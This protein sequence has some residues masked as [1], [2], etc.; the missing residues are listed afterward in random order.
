M[1]VRRSTVTITL[2]AALLVPAG[3]GLAEHATAQAAPSGPSITLDAAP[4]ADGRRALT[5]PIHVG[6]VGGTIESVTGTATPVGVTDPKRASA[7]TGFFNAGHSTWNSNALMP[8]R[9]YRVTVVA[10]APDGVKATQSATVTTANPAARL[11]A[12][13]TPAT[14]RLVGVGMPVIVNL[15]R[16]VTT[17]SG[18]AAVQKALTVTTSK[19][20][21]RASW[22]WVSSTQVQYRPLTFWPAGT[23]VRVRA[24]LAGVNAGRGIWGTTDMATRFVV[25]RAQ[26]IK[27]DGKRHT[28]VITRNGKT[29]RTG[30]VS[31]GKAGFSTRSGIKVIMAREVSRRMRSSTL[32]IFEGPNA[33]DLQVP[34]AM[35][36]TNTGE[37]LHGAPWNHRIGVA[38]VSHGCT[39]ITLSNAKWVYANSLIGDP[40]VTTGAGRTAELGN[41]LGGVWNV[42][43]TAWKARSAL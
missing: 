11:T 28:F 15:N 36:L 37:F 8:A 2:A 30:G 4:G 12:R 16:A 18:R 13:I 17:K 26:I 41:G 20:I 19:P 33:Y 32:G 40:V 5:A 35:R 6:V 29:I 27:V 34:Y 3:A 7:V 42:S 22:G 39:N 38:N 21:G 14:G 25:G 9:V 24:E 23:T 1:A 43:W 10:A 31:L